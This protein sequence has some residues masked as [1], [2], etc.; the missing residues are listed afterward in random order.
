MVGSP[1][2]PAAVRERPPRKGPI[3]RYFIPLKSGSP[4]FFSSLSL[5]S[6]ADGSEAV[7]AF[8]CAASTLGFPSFC[9][10]KVRVTEHRTNKASTAVRTSALW[11]MNSM[12]P[13]Q[14]FCM[15]NVNAKGAKGTN[16]TSGL[17]SQ[18]A[19][20][21]IFTTERTGVHR[22]ATGE[23]NSQTFLL[24]RCVLTLPSFGAT[25]PHSQH[26][27]DETLVGFS[28][29]RLECFKHLFSFLFETERAH[30]ATTVHIQ[31]RDRPDRNHRPPTA[32]VGRTG[33][34]GAWP[35]GASPHLQLGPTGHRRGYLPASP[36]GLLPPAHA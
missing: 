10:E 2:I 4:S 22:G 36:T 32:M 13:E 23:F 27:H 31:R 24:L 20:K 17:R 18:F 8:F 35:P 5:S 12:A 30:N 28:L 14:E 15:A 21:E 1:G 25:Y 16:V 33:H 11:I 7:S 3:E 34:C 19:S 29:R 26:K 6:F 9:W